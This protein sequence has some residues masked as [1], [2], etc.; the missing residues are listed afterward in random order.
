MKKIL[1][2][3]SN[4]NSNIFFLEYSDGEMYHNKIFKFNISN[5]TYTADYN[6]DFCYDKTKHKVFTS[7]L[8]KYGYKNTITSEE[9]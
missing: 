2:T 5:R 9:K 1:L 3:K 6:I 8:D 4:I 7:I